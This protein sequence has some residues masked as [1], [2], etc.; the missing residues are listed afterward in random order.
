[1]KKDNTLKTLKGFRDL[2]P[3]EVRIKQKAIKILRETFEFFGFQPLETPTLEY[4]KTLLGK[5]GEEADRL[6]YTFKDKGGRKVGLRYD[7][8][9]PTAKVLA[10]YQN[11]IPLPFKRYQIQNAF[12]AE[13]P[14]RGRL[15]EFTQCDIDIFGIR[16]P[17]AD[18]EIILIIYTA[19]KNLGF[20]EFKIMINSRQVLFSILEKAGINQKEDQLSTLRSIDKLGKKP[21][22]EVKDELRAKGLKRDQVN[23]LLKEISRAEPDKELEMIFSFLKKNNLPKEFY[24]FTPYLVRGLDYYTRAIFETS[25]TRPK[26]GSVTGGGRYDNLVSQLGGPD[27][28][29]TGT[30]IGLERII[31]TIKENDLWPEIKAG[32]K[33]KVL[34]TIFSP[35]L[36]EEA[37]RAAR[38]L[39]EKKIPTELYLDPEE[40]LEKQL[41]YADRT[42]IPYAII[43]GPDEVENQL[44]SLKDLAKKKQKTLS[45]SQAVSQLKT[46]LEDI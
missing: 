14:Q 35:E 2:L 38:Q 30:T 46:R 18:G 19:L 4:A 7:L 32:K 12:R 20:E 36:E 13:K 27:V 31:E 21:Q 23:S 40:K 42:G 5:Y 34:V 16:S 15:R 37:V 39:R 43:I 26:I 10:L 22:S 29:G 17:L 8:T 3:E 41:K 9:V 45:L 11:K 28:T 25:V 33:I 44:V 1:M 24:Q 6:I